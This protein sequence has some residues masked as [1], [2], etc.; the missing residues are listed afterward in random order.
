VVGTDRLS[1]EECLERIV[2]KLEEL[3]YLKAKP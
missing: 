2:S 1:P 3:R